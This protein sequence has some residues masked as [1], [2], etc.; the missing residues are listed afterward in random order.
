[1]GDINS[2][3][4]AYT[5]NNRIDPKYYEK[6]N[7]KRGLRNPDGSGVMAGVTNICNV[8]GYVINEGEKSPDEG[9]LVFRGYNINDLVSN[10]VAENRFG[11]E[12]IAYLLLGGKLPTEHQLENFRE[13]LDNNRELPEGFFEDMILKAPSKNIMNKMSR[14]VLALYSYDDVPDNTEVKHEVDTAVSIIAKMPVI[15]VS[16]YHV[17]QRYYNHKSMFMHPLIPGQSTA[18]TILS[19]LRP[20]RQF[21]DE[22]AKLL[23]VMLML[24]AEHGG[25]NNSTFTCRVLTSSGTDPYAAYSAAIGSLKGP[26]HGGANHKVIQMHQYIK[27]NVKNWDDEGEVADFLRKIL[28]KEAGDGTGL[29]YGMGHAVYTLSDPRAVILKQNAAKMAIG[30]EFEAEYRLL[31]MIERLTPELFKE[32]KGDEKKMCANVDMYSG[33]VYKMLGIPEDLFTPLFAVSRMAGWCAH[34]FEESMT[35]KRIIRPAYKSVSKEKAYI[36]LNNR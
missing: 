12:E 11:Y 22:E 14:A 29:I 9:K 26:R 7:V 24:H 32:V 23:D 34:R 5:A 1:M 16:A 30:S 8:H 27:D 2:L 20:D 35:G 33:F 4:E 10:V 18:E 31:E 25:G 15:M 13:L 28:R 17:K 36:P 3:Y 19:M 6:F 21:T